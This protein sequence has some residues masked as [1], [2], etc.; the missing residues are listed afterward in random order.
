MYQPYPH[1]TDFAFDETSAPAPQ[2]HA[3]NRPRKSTR[4]AGPDDV[5]ADAVA[6]SARFVLPT[7]R[8]S[9]RPHSSNLT[10]HTLTGRVPDRPLAPPSPRPAA[11]LRKFFSETCPRINPRCDA[12]R[13]DDTVVDVDTPMQ[14][15]VPACREADWMQV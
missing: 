11:G 14:I 9:G 15:Q 1:H 4:D 2:I 10:G 12:I 6:A 13:A 5:D 7:G 3:P 8:M